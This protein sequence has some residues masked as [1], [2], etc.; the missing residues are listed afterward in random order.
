MQQMQAAR[1]ALQNQALGN[2]LGGQGA[3]SAAPA[4]AGTAPVMASGGQMGQGAGDPSQPPAVM[5]PASLSGGMTRDPMFGLQMA[6]DP[7]AAAK[8]YIDRAYPQPTDFVKS[9]VSA[10]IDP[11]S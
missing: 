5:N 9:L 10:G 11:N 4:G 8:S 7:N 1:M 6:F 2:V 3:G